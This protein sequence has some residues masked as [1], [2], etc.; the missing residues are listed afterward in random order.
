[1]LKEII[2]YEIKYRLKRKSTYIYFGVFFIL[3]LLLMGF[4]ATEMKGGSVNIFGV[5]S[6]KIFLNSGYSLFSAM[7]F[8]SL[9]AIFVFPAI[10]GRSIY[11]D[12]EYDTHSIYFTMPISKFDYVFGRFFGS[13]IAM[14]FIN[15]GIAFGAFFAQFFPTAE[16]TRFTDFSFYAFLN[17]YFQIIIPNTLLVGVILFS[18]VLIFRNIMMVYV[19]TAVMF[20]AYLVSFN[21]MA[22]IDAHSKIVLFDPFG[23]L[24][25]ISSTR[26]WT[27]PDKNML[28]VPYTGLLI[29]NRLI[30]ISLSVAVFIFSYR[31]FQ[32]SIFNFQLKSKKQIIE[33]NEIKNISEVKPFEKDYTVEFSGKANRSQFLRLV[34]HEFKGIT[35]TFYFKVLLV[36][37]ALMLM[38]EPVQF[39][40][41][42]DAELLPITTNFLLN[43]KSAFLVFG[44]IILTF[45]TGELVWTE[46]N[47]KINSLYDVLPVPTWLP[48]TS[49][50]S[51]LL[52]VQFVFMF[53]ILIC[54]ML[55]QTIKGFFDYQF[56][57]YF[58]DLFG[59]TIFSYLLYAVLTMLIHVIV[60]NKFLGHFVMLLFFILTMFYDSIGIEQYI[61]R[62]SESPS[63]QLSEMN[64]F[65]HNVLP[66][67]AHVFY[68]LFFAGLLSILTFLFWVRG[69]ETSF[70]YRL[71]LARMRFTKPV[72]GFT[73]GF[74]LLFIASGFY[75]YYNTHIL[76][77]FNTSASN[78][79]FSFDYEKKYKKYK[80]R[81]ELTVTDVKIN[82]DIFPEDRDFKIK[83]SY[84]LKNKTNLPIDTLVIHLNNDLK[85]NNI[86]INKNFKTVI[87]DNEFGYH[88]YKLETQVVPNDSISLDFD[89]EYITKGFV[90]NGSNNDIVYNGTF[91]SNYKYMPMLGYNA[92][93]ELKDDEIRKKYGLKPRERAFPITDS[94]NY[95]MPSGGSI[96][97]MI[98]FEAVVS[99]SIDQIAIAPGKLVKEWTKNNRRFFHYKPN[100]KIAN[101]YS[102]LSAK[103]KV[104]KDK[105]NDINLEIYYQSNHTY[106]I[107]KIMSSMKKSLEY[108]SKNFSQYQYDDLRIVEFPYGWFAQSFATTIPF[109]ENMGF[110]EKTGEDVLGVDHLTWIVNH[111]I[112]HQWW[113]HQVG[114]ANVQGETFIVEVLT[115]YSALMVLKSEFSDKQINRLMRYELDRYLRG[116][117]RERK[118]EL[119]I[120]LVEGQGYIHYYKGMHVMNTLQDYIGSENINKALRKIIKKYALNDSIYPTSI[121]VINCFKEVTPDSLK[122]I[123][124]DM[125]ENITLY[126]NKTLQAN[127][128]KKANGKYLVKIEIEA[129]KFRA[130]SLGNET[131]IMVDDLIEIGIL[132]SNE[133]LLY[134]KKHKINQKVNTLE[135]EVDKI[136]AKAGIDLFYKLIDKNTNDNTI[137]VK[138]L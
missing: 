122:Y 30:Y 134:M 46:R 37:A 124:A 21:Y 43:I 38:L 1:M 132:D 90:N 4:A 44:L 8:I 118:K 5:N 95:T 58:K 129:R 99:T 105:F 42:A 112:A 17:P 52:L 121:D 77:K 29:I 41:A 3:T 100:R 13:F 59:F 86:K 32:F 131:E 31:K 60:N 55:L 23:L 36:T 127:F 102:F 67:Y 69:N 103:Y 63:F 15:L 85:L 74:L 10:F 92:E 40:G 18:M 47:K 7:S 133:E 82:I 33:N 117:T 75:I 39:N 120:Y 126:E 81:K 130:D 108:Y 73:F 34:K 135:I 14:I 96:F 49:K 98:T 109:S 48:F 78:E 62:Y 137:F 110:T 76:N 19:A 24:T 16:A 61:F 45:C 53:V 35:K 54:G 51:A 106:N 9:F 97:K 87:D 70:K 20:V 2:L 113:G 26:Y 65:G 138:S 71:K 114:A 72:K 94:S 50:L 123:Y 84:I 128:T 66:F 89:Y 79:Q 111:E 27:I 28:D 119:P 64:G 57:I 25:F 56:D 88:I 115:Q 68:W 91:I 125:F 22:D 11:R 101:F 136:P 80:N 6:N 116:R 12:F 107:D 93:L 104:K 83:G